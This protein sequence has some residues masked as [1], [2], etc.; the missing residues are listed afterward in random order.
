MWGRGA[1]CVMR[2]VGQGRTVCGAVCGAGAQ[3][4]MR[5]VGQGEQ[6]R[7]ERKLRAGVR[8]ERRGLWKFLRSLKGCNGGA[9]AGTRATAGDL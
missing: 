3:C 6:R 5:C 1:Q 9:T 4:V 2:C 7:V 8:V